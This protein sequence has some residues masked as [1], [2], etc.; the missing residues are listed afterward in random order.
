MN[1]PFV[2]LKTQYHNL[3][4]EIDA[5][6][7]EV[8][9][10]T[11]FISGKY[12]RKFEE[13]FA[14]YVGTDHCIACGNGTD[15]LQLTLMAMGIGQGDEVIVPANSFIA[16]SEAVTAAGARVV[17]CDA[18]AQ[19][20]NIDTGRIEKLITPKTRAII[21]VHLYGKPAEMDEIISIAQKHNLRVIEDSAQAHG[22]RYKGKT[23]GTMG[24]AACFSFY[25][26]K[27]LGAYGDA[28]AVVTADH[29]L[30]KRIRMLA[31]HGRI[32]KYNHEFEGFNSRMDGIQAAVL[33]IKLKYLDQW[34]ENRRRVAGEYRRELDGMAG[35]TL[36]AEQDYQRAV[37]HLFVIKLDKRDALQAWLKEKGIS[38]G[39]HY[40]I[41]LPF[42]KAYDYLNHTEK[43]FPVTAANQKRIL[44]LPVYP[45]MSN[46]QVRYVC[47]HI[48]EF[49]HKVK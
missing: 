24:D 34:I 9:E 37:Y 19:S 27:N 31:N 49:F 16:T 8:I 13:A 28:G 25:P 5:A 12:A 36:P 23:A 42:L 30:A 32:D 15:A 1:I 3:K 21:A 40:P 4:R 20:D 17:F 11:A 2:D 26:G 41:G 7:A 18:D 14:A 44:S 47:N 38:S 39:I 22:V 33:E 48:K 45:E 46:D 29:E 6:I 10:N 35:I 43:D